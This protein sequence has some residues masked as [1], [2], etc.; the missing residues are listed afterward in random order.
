MISTDP[1]NVLYKMN[2]IN[3]GVILPRGT[4]II[5]LDLRKTRI[6]PLY[7]P[8]PEN[9]NI[10]RSCIFRVTG[11][12]YLWQFSILDADPNGT[13]YKDYTSKFLYLIF[14]TTNFLVLNMQMVQI[15]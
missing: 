14:L 11:S 2:S 3:G 4:S 15:Q 10:E 9:D 1:D 8:N 7:V 6:R 5:G 12:C 13:V